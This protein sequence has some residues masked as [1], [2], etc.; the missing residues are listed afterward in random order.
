MNVSAIILGNSTLSLTWKH[1]ENVFDELQFN[2]S[3]TATVRSTGAVVAN[4][5]ISI[6]S[7]DKPQEVFNL[8][9]ALTCKDINF[10]VALVNDCRL[11]HTIAPIPTCKSKRHKNAI[12]D[13]C[14]SQ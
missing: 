4:Y 14:Y 3:V 10:T 12:N 6:S 5:N 8:S 9:E 7:D 13:S 11:S 2:Y 1:P